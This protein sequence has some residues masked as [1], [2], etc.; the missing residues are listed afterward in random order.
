MSKSWPPT[1]WT[2]PPPG[3]RTR[4]RSCGPSRPNRS[5]NACPPTAPPS[6]QAHDPVFTALQLSGTLGNE[7]DLPHGS[8][9]QQVFESTGHVLERVDGGADRVECPRRHHV[10]QVAEQRALL[11]RVGH[12]PDAPV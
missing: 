1:S 3:T 2:G 4:V 8:P 6:T 5:S 7:R 11:C 10:Q 9:A 12:G